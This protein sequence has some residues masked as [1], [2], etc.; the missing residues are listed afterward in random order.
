MKPT[1]AQFG[2]SLGSTA[3]WHKDDGGRG[4]RG[5]LLVCRGGAGRAQMRGSWQGGW[6]PMAGRGLGRGEHLGH[7]GGGFGG[8][9]TGGEEDK[10]EKSENAGGQIKS[11]GRTRKM[12]P[13]FSALGAQLFFRG[14]RQAGASCQRLGGKGHGMGS[15]L[16]CPG[17]PMAR[18]G[19]GRRGM[20]DCPRP[21][22]S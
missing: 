10:R 6:D 20:G 22:R 3:V 16:G 18:E 19:R 17:P 11:G 15:F 9:K 8:P 4:H 13:R 1:R 2:S 12:E 21:A 14:S 5:I 7:P